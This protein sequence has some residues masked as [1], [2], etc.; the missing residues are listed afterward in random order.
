MVTLDELRAALDD[1][2]RC[3]GLERVRLARELSDAAMGT[4]AAV[5]D[6][7]VWLATRTASRREVAQALGVSEAAVGKAVRLH[8]ARQVGS[9]GPLS[10]G[11][12]SDRTRRATRSKAA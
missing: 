11:A 8:N 2:Q 1:L 10:E 12:E 5:G 3:R 6:E 4:L 7:A 9:K